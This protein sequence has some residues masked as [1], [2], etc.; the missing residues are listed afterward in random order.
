MSMTGPPMTKREN[1]IRTIQRNDPA[2]V[3]YRYD[4]SLTMLLPA[5]NARPRDGGIDDWGVSWIDTN[6]EQG[7]YPG[8]TPAITIDQIADYTA[9]SSD[10]QD[11]TADLRRQIAHHPDKDTLFIA[12]NEAVLFERAKLLLGT[13]DFLMACAAD[14]HQLCIL[15]DKVTNYQVQLTEAIMQSGVDGV[16]FTDDWGMQNTLFIN[17]ELWRQLFKP[18][19]QQ[20]YDVVKCQHGIVLQHSC[21]CINDIVPD[22]IEIGVDVLDPCQPQ[23]NDIFHWK[24]KFGRQLTFMGGLDTQGYLSFAPPAEIKK[25][26]N[27]VLAT[28]SENGGYIAAPSHTIT[29]PSANRQAMIEAINEF[30]A[31]RI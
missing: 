9:P 4:G 30:N 27:E 16:R 25:R 17:P 15:I 12:R 11:I 22:L 10:W 8:E 23:S 31:E 13:A 24:R 3:P 5:V 2:F 1:L 6:S 29:L 7:S 21:G 19:L 18:R 26:V 28:M 20:M 14:S